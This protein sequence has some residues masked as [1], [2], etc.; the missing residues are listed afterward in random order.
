MTAKIGTGITLK[1]AGAVSQPDSISISLETPYTF[2]THYKHGTMSVAPIPSIRGMMLADGVNFVQNFVWPRPYN[3]SLLAPKSA[4]TAVASATF[5]RTQFYISTPSIDTILTGDSINLIRTLNHW[6][7]TNRITWRTNRS[8]AGNTNE[9]YFD[10]TNTHAI[11]QMCKFINQ[12]G[13]EGSDY[14]TEYDFSGELFADAS[15]AAAGNF[16][17]NSISSGEHGNGYSCIWNTGR[18]G[19]TFRTYLLAAGATQFTGGFNGT[20]PGP[21][22]GTYQYGYTYVREADGAESGISPLVEINNDGTGNVA[23]SSIA[24]SGDS[25]VTYKRIYRTAAGG[26]IMYRVDEI[27]NA[28][29]SY[30]DSKTDSQ[31]TGFDAI[32]YD[33][34]L[35]RSYGEGYGPRVRWLAH[36]QGQWFGAGA[37]LAADYNCGVA[38]YT[39][40]SDVVSFASLSGSGFAVV[41]TNW[42]GR[43]FQATPD[44]EVYNIVSVNTAGNSFTLNRNFEGATGVSS[45][46]VVKDARDP[47]ELHWTEPGMP[48]NWVSSLKGPNSPDNKGCTGLFAAFGSIVYFTRQN[49]WQINGSGS[50]FQV[51]KVTDKSGCV[52]GNAVAM[53]GQTLYWLGLDGI[54][55]WSGAGEPVNITTPPGQDS[56]LRGQDET[57]ARLNLSHAH[58]SVAVFDQK[59]QE[60]RWYVPLDGSKYNNYAFVLDTK[61]GTFSIDTCEDVTFSSSIYGSDGE[62]RIFTGDITGAIYEQGLSTADGGYGIEPVRTILSSTRFSVTVSGTP[63]S[64]S[65]DGYWGCPIWHLDDTGDFVRYCVASNTSNS[66]TFRRA[67]AD[68]PPYQTTQFVL[69]GILMYISTGRFDFGD[70]FREKIVPAYIVSHSPESD[71]QYFFMYA[72]G[73]QDF[74]VPTIGWTAGD[75]TVGNSANDFGPRRRFRA[76]KQD[77]LH[78]WALVCVEPGCSPR[79]TSVAIEV[80]GPSNLEI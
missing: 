32:A 78:G 22:S 60:M 25:T 64:T 4:L 63:F 16:W 52:G 55:A 23:L 53:D 48:S 46:Y 14:Y 18:A 10:G 36:Y 72:Y 62:D 28:T 80:R 47:Y 7:L 29:T 69:G 13:V 73:Q 20:Q 49:V 58:N 3:N 39:K 37:V 17:I 9:V 45:N 15:T 31:I 42:I 12:T 68:A 27:P 33:P 77:V 43:T 34:S 44:S 8:W 56:A 54:Y 79:F 59:R 6:A 66:I 26:G 2:Q 67:V 21:G 19:F 35:Y 30:T 24:A 57:I 71:G 38:S 11:T 50:E 51:V 74:S 1:A 5:A 40:G 41:C 61:S 70:R 76:R 75:L 65:N